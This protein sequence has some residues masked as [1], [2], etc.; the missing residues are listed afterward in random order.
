MIDGCNLLIQLEAPP[1]I[2]TVLAAVRFP[3]C[4]SYAIEIDASASSGS[5]RPVRLTNTAVMPH[6]VTRVERRLLQF[7]RHGCVI[8]TAVLVIACGRE[9]SVNGHRRTESAAPV[10]VEDVQIMGTDS[11]FTVF[12]STRTSIRDQ[13]AQV[14]EIPRV[15]NAVVR[16]RLKTSTTQVIMFPEDPSGTSVSFG[17]TRSADGRWIALAPWKIVIPAD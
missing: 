3:D 16:P 12:Y 9:S 8:L 6:P 14:E 4:C 15:W 7:L 2:S 13:Q 11:E 17:F 5:N 1:A 10:N